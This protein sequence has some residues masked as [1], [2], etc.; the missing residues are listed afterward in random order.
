MPNLIT[1][2]GREHNP[3]FLVTAVSAGTSAHE[4]FGSAGHKGST[5]SLSIVCMVDL[6][7]GINQSYGEIQSL[8]IQVV[9]LVLD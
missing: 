7:H 1:D 4:H 2:A 3:R 5:G 8:Q 6:N 9:D